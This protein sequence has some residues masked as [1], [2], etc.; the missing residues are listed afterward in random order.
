[1]RIS[2]KRCKYCMLLFLLLLLTGCSVGNL[3]VDK[4][5]EAV[6]FHQKSEEPEEQEITEE[7]A[8]FLY[9]YQNLSRQRPYPDL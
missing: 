4:I 7:Q 5:K 9:G 6:K 8:A 2:K 3:D 1:M